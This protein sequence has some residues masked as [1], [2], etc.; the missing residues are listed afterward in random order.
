MLKIDKLKRCEMRVLLTRPY[1]QSIDMTRQLED[2]GCGVSIEPILEIIPIRYQKHIFKYTKAFV[3]TSKHASSQ[4]ANSYDIDKT[5]PIYAVGTATAESLIN[6]GFI[7]THIADGDAKSLLKLIQEK[8]K[9]EDGLITYFSG[10][11]IT[12]D[13]AHFLAMNGYDAQRVVCYK[14]LQTQKLSALTQEM[15]RR[16]EIDCMFFMSGRTA[17]RFCQ[18]CEVND[19]IKSLKSIT[20]N[21]ISHLKWKDIKTASHPSVESLLNTLSDVKRSDGL[22][23][24]GKVKFQP[25][26][27]KIIS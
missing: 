11:H 13:L 23:K 16:K 2:M 18:L 8:Q 26:R 6:S 5:T 19:L 9:P 1:L 4:I 3:V 22:S 15:I 24:L 20:A 10:W 7:N 21:I 27:N 12:Q 14:A 17:E 25:H